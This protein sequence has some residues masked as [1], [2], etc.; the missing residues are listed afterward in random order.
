V[1]GFPD[2]PE[3]SARERLAIARW[4]EGFTPDSLSPEQRQ[5]LA[6]A[7]PPSV[8]RR[9]R[10]SSQ[11]NRDLRSRSTVALYDS[12][13]DEERLITR[14]P[15]HSLPD[16]DY[17]LSVGEMAAIT[18]AT[19]RKIRNWADGGLLPFFREGNDRRFYSAALIRAFVLQRTPTHTKAVVAATAQGE[20]AQAFQ[21]LAATVGRAALDMP[22]QP[23]EQLT[24]LADE[25]SSASQ[26]MADGWPSPDASK[27]QRQTAQKKGGPRFR[28]PPLGR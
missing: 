24:R 13:T 8:S 18:G 17:P 25:L 15:W 1:P 28:D 21:L 2:N 14:E 4:A 20:A 22:S 26:L 3:L 16:V 10:E 12:L 5:L 11:N 9:Q 23:A 19:E 7:P 27:T 6:E